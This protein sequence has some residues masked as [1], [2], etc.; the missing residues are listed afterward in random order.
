MNLRRVGAVASIGLLVALPGAAAAAAADSGSATVGTQVEAW[1]HTAT[2]DA[3]AP[4][5]TVD[6][7]MLPPADAETYPADTLHVGISAG[8]PTAATFVELDLFGANIPKGSQV[9]AGTLT[10]PVDTAEGDGSLEP[11]T[12]KLVACHVTG[13]FSDANGSLAKPPK[14]DCDA[15]SA[16]AKYTAEPRPTF[17]VDLA[18]FAAKWAGGDTAAIAILPAAEAV[19]GQQTWHVTFWGKDYGAGAEEST[20]PAGSEDA[21]PITARLNYAPKQQT[22]PPPN[23]PG[24][25]GVP[26]DSPA[27]AVDSVDVAGPAPADAPP[28]PAPKAGSPADAGTPPAIMAEPSYTTVGYPY[29]IAWVMPLVLLI[30]FVV[31]GRSLTKKLDQPRGL[32]W[33]IPA[34]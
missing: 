7:S 21:K 29:P 26:S 3:C 28:P 24:T 4:A 17:T 1:Y 18:K 23:D 25:G 2:N 12:A 20:L 16:P 34:K 19:E 14:T 15:A 27:P 8:T 5:G 13:F 31:T 9:V 10:L 22:T 32:G 30:G 11:Q 6:C 33:I